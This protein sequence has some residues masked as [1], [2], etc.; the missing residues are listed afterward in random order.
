MECSQ[1]LESTICNLCLQFAYDNNAPETNIWTTEDLYTQ[2]L[3]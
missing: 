3:V 1:G 2:H